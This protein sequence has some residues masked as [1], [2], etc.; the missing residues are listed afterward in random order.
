MSAPEIL[1]SVAKSAPNLARMLLDL[2]WTYLTLGRRVRKARQAFEKQ[3]LLK[4]MS[5]QDAESLSTC[6]DDLKKSIL[7]ALRQGM[8]L[9]VTR[10]ASP[11][12]MSPW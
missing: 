2:S 11:M 5:R 4:G 9:G 7:A 1:K 3:L 10:T 6:Y 12:T 8:S